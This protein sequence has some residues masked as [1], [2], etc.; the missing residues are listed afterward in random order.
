[1]DGASAKDI[2]E[3][4]CDVV[5]LKDEHLGK[6]TLKTKSSFFEVNSKFSKA[7]TQKFNG[8]LVNNREI[9]VNRDEDSPQMTKKR[10]SPRKKSRR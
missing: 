3:L 5:R 8:L 9:R 6:I 1:M 2:K 4:I 10:R 7:V